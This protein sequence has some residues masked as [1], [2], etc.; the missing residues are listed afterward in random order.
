M[1]NNN[2]SVVRRIAQEAIRNITELSQLVD[3]GGSSDSEANFSAPATASVSSRAG[4]GSS[5]RRFR[6]YE[7]PNHVSEVRLRFPTTAGS[8]GREHA[9]QNR[10]VVRR[11][12]VGGGRPSASATVTQYMVILLVNENTIPLWHEK[13]Q[14][15]KDGRILTGMDIDR[16][17]HED[18]LRHELQLALPIGFKNVPFQIMKNCHDSIIPPNI[19]NGRKIDAA[20]LLRSIAP[21][22]FIC[23]QLMDDPLPDDILEITTLSPTVEQPID[24]NEATVAATSRQKDAASFVIPI[25]D[26]APSDLADPVEILKFLQNN[27]V[28]GRPLEV[29]SID[30]IPEGETKYITVNREDILR[31]TFDELTYIHNPRNT[32]QVDFMGEDCIDLGGPRKEWI[33]LMNQYI[34]KKYFENGL[35]PLLSN[36]YFYVGLMFSLSMLQNGQLPSFLSEAVLQDLIVVKANDACVAQMQLGMESFGMHSALCKFP[37]LAFL[38]RPGGQNQSLT[39]QKLYSLSSHA[40]LNKDQML[41]TLRKKHTRCLSNMQGKWQLIGENQELLQ[42]H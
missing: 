37:Q 11:R 12:G 9:G 40:F 21:T 26:S 34:K 33:R 25:L 14:L 29:S 8:F 32:F 35:G 36:E 19:P 38:L 41:C 20:L 3:A 5:N 28:T 27:I 39:V 31:G 23:V 2:A 30:S 7:R 6:S 42:L 4:Q 17:W 18:M 15:E 1:E 13:A 10:I 22:G 16:G 24:D